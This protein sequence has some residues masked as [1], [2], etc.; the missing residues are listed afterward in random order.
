MRIDAYEFQAK[1]LIAE[2]AELS[3][4]QWE[5]SLKHGGWNPASRVF[6]AFTAVDG[7]LFGH[8]MFDYVAA[9]VEAGVLDTDRWGTTLF[10][11]R[12]SLDYFLNTVATYEEEFRILDRW[13]F[14]LLSLVGR[15]I[16]T[17]FVTGP[18]IADG[19]LDHLDQTGQ[20]KQL[21]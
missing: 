9:A 8:E 21:K 6:K 5:E 2:G 15:E 18:E 14:A 16:E 17:G 20:L 4:A 1:P 13:Y 12:Q 11:S 7:E 10:A 19:L 3:A